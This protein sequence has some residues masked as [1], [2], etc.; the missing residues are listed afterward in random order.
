MKTVLKR[1]Q[2]FVKG[3]VVLC[4]SLVLAVLTAFAVP[5]DWAYF[6]YPEISAETQR[7]LGYIMV[8]MFVGAVMQIMNRADFDLDR[9]FEVCTNL[10]LLELNK[11]HQAG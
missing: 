7:A 1:C 4:V 10:I 3:E 9:Y 8:S 2:S 6:S 5:P 11:L